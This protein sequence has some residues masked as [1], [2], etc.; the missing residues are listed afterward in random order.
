[1]HYIIQKN[2]FKEE[3]YNKIFTAL[4]RLGL[5]YEIVDCLPFLE[6]YEFISDRKDI[7]PF[8]SVKMARLSAKNN[9]V[10]G[11][12]YGGNHD[13]T[14]YSKEYGINLL[15]SGSI[16]CEFGDKTIWDNGFIRLNM[17]LFIRPCK[18]SKVFTGKLFTQ[19]KWEDFVQ[20]SLTNGHTTSLDSNTLIQVAIPKKIYKEARVWVIG[21]KIITSSYYF[22]HG[23]IDYEENV[24]PEGLEF[25]QKMIDLYQPAEAFVIDICLCELGWKIVEINCINCSGF[26]K[27]DLQK[28]LIGLEDHFNPSPIVGDDMICPITK[29]HCYDECCPVGA[30]CNLW[31]N[32]IKSIN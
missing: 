13:F 19:T 26:Y 29:T 6:D 31:G 23:N 9:W 10:P 32:N 8:G 1:M 4:D 11:S 15:N 28:I 16:I 20:E 30:T 18:D 27:G 3:N 24:E 5:S 17:M 12:F 25:A 7:F 22:F 14:I 21:G 2:V